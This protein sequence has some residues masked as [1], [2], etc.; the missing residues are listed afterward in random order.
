[1]RLKP[2]FD[3]LLD[4]I[5]Q[6]AKVLDLGC[7]SGELLAYLYQHKD[8]NGVGLEMDPHA[9]VNC[10]SHGVNVIQAD[11]NAANLDDLFEAQAFDLVLTTQTL[12]AMQRPDQLIDNMLTVG[13]QAVVTFPNFGY[14]RNRVQVFFG[15]HM[16]VS[17]TLPH[18]W[19]NTPNTHLCT[20]ADFEDLCRDKNIRII[21]QRVVGGT[22]LGARL[23]PNWFGEVALYHIEKGLGSSV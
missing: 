5:P 11:L 1:M 18:Q 17:S 16:P 13:K 23:A 22:W 3:L 20:F 12:Q 4:W 8:V 2:E 19:Y 15:G 6:G 14:W 9:I 21:E 10:L 7:G